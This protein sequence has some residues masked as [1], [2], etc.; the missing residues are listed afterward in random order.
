MLLC[1]KLLNFA[2]KN[3]ELGDLVSKCCDGYISL[4]N[5]TEFSEL[6]KKCLD[7]ISPSISHIIWG[8]GGAFFLM[9]FAILMLNLFE[10]KFR[11]NE[12]SIIFTSIIILASFLIFCGLLLSTF[13]AISTFFK[14]RKIIK[15]YRQKTIK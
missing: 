15:E 12:F 2:Q 13:S 11:Y 7:K 6:I 1:V 8:V 14:Q 9:I 4:K 5:A 10:N 3:K